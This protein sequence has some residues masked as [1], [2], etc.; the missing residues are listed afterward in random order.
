MT[1]EMT[2]AVALILAGFAL[3]LAQRNAPPRAVG[4]VLAALVLMTAAS[5]G[6]DALSFVPE[7]V[8]SLIPPAFARL[9]ACL[10]IL[11]VVTWWVPQWLAR[12][13]R[14]WA[15]WGILAISEASSLI[16]LGTPFSLGELLSSGIAAILIVTVAAISFQRLRQRR[17][18]LNA[19]G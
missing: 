3:L 7:G 9:L 1:P 12:I 16:L 4:G 18:S 13:D 14:M 17:S 2:G 11:A 15:A 10:V 5:L 8:R 19:A 6:A